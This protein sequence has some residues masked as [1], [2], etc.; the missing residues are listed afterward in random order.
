MVWVVMLPFP[1]SDCSSLAE[2]L[3]SALQTVHLSYCAV[4]QQHNVWHAVAYK[5]FLKQCGTSDA[6]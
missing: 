3:E 2:G 5:S 4:T 1:P 6:I